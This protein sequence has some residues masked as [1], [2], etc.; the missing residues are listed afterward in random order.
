M[1]RL[2]EVLGSGEFGTVH[3][4]VWSPHETGGQ[5]VKEEVA[6][7]TIDRGVED[8][9]KVKFLQEA[10][11]MAQFKHC[12]I[13]RIRG[14]AIE[15]KVCLHERVYQSILEESSLKIFANSSAYDYK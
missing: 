2:C 4:G 3:R 15:E 13:V 7:K 1:C 8:T 6:V 10:A 11:I 14:I 5:V 9:E 12:N